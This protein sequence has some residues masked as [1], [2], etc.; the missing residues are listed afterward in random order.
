MT[1]DDHDPAARFRALTTGNFAADRPAQPMPTVEEVLALVRQIPPAYPSIATLADMAACTPEG[2]PTRAVLDAWLHA[3]RQGDER[4]V[5][6]VGATVWEGMDASARQTLAGL[7]D[8][9]QSAVID[10]GEVVWVT[11]VTPVPR[12]LSSAP[13]VIQ[14]TEI[15]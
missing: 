5:I 7:V 9:R 6:H 15:V 10:P 12:L 3:R 4:P 1:H 8:L 2:T 11:L 13:Y 14:R